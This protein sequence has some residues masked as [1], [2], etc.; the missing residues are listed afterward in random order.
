MAACMRNPGTPLRPQTALARRASW[1]VALLVAVLALPGAAQ[2]A[3]SKAATHIVHLRSG[4]TLGD[5]AAAV[6]AAHG[7]VTGRLPIIRGLAVRLSRRSRAA[8][9]RDPRVAAVSV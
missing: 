6:R 5:V 7:R 2:A 1:F 9:A 4:V 3:P 8:L